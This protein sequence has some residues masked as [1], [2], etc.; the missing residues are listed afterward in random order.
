MAKPGAPPIVRPPAGT[1][2]APAPTPLGPTGVT[3]ADG[4]PGDDALVAMFNLVRDELVST[5]LYLLDREGAG[6]TCTR[7]LTVAVHQSMSQ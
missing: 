2:P 6:G 7:S 3:P 1:E 5:L 4:R